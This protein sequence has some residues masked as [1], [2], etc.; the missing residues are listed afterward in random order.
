MKNYT[1]KKY[2]FGNPFNTHAVERK[3]VPSTDQVPYVVLCED[4]KHIKYRMGKADKVYGLG[5]AV[6]GINKRGWIY[7]A[8]CSDDPLHTETKRSLYGAH[9]FV[10][11]DGENVFGIFVDYPDRVVFDIGYTS[12]DDLEISVEFADFNL[13]IISGE[14]PKDIVFGF[15]ELIGK[16]YTAPFWSFGFQQSRWSYNTSRDVMN[17]INSYKENDFP[18]DAVYLDIDYMEAFKD[19]TV[20]SKSFPDFVDFIKEAKS[21]NIHLVPI[22]DAGVKIEDGYEVYEEGKTNGYFC[23]NEKGEDF[24]AAVWPGK[25]CFPDFLNSQAAEWFGMKYRV[26]TEMGIDGF[27]NDMN[28]PAMFYYI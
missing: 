18:L 15:R 12:P 1:L 11:V 24:V 20:N 25:V 10:I 13:Y 8:Y 3:I 5:E 6:R 14:T 17:V 28:E 9:P 26:L 19:F 7:E 21:Q 22:I 23:R 2:V 27:W 4:S 16:S